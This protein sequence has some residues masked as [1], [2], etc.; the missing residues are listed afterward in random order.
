M[1]TEGPVWKARAKQTLSKVIVKFFEADPT[2]GKELF[3]EFNAWR[4][5]EKS[6]Q[7]RFHE[8][9]TLFE[10]GD[11]RNE[12]LGWPYVISCMRLGNNI[13][14][15]EEEE[16]S[17]K[18]VFLPL[19]YHSGFVNDYLS[20]EKEIKQY[21]MS[22]GKMPLVNAVA[23]LMRWHG[24]SVTEAKESLR[25]TCLDL[26]SEY[27]RL[28]KEYFKVHGDTM[29]SNLRRWFDLFEVV[30]SGNL[31]WLMMSY[32]HDISPDGSGYRDYYN[33]RCSEGAI[34]PD[35][36]TQT[37]GVLSGGIELRFKDQQPDQ[38]VQ[39]QLKVKSSMTEAKQSDTKSVHHNGV[40]PGLKKLRKYEKTHSRNVSFT[41]P[42]LLIRLD[43]T[44]LEDWRLMR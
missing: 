16:V 39:P 2:L 13:H 30:I 42:S 3:R 40:Q 33:K 31:W 44:A 23:L 41:D 7:K 34:W 43:D 10:Y 36:C 22:D 37:E 28:K 6:V 29:S 25:Q 11:D 38:E 14:L 35:D 12:D 27:F 20:W 24:Q 17:V 26:D 21:E 1:K 32:R 15:T 4:S 9:K 8:Y 18:P 5:G 19:K